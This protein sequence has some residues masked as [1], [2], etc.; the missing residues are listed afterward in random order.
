MAAVIHG[1]THWERL[2]C[3]ELVVLLILRVV[4]AVALDQDPT[5]QRQPKVVEAVAHIQ[6]LEFSF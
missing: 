6:V 2:Q 3:Q 5:L 4:T 1:I